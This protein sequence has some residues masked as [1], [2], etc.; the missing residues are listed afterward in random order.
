MLFEATKW[1][2]TAGRKGASIILVLGS[3]FAA[4]A[5]L[6]DGALTTQ[7][8]SDESSPRLDTSL[9]GFST[10]AE[11]GGGGSSMPLVLNATGNGFDFDL[12][13]IDR[14]KVHFYLDSPLFVDPLH[15][16]VESQIFSF[17]GRNALGL[18]A[19]LDVPF[20]PA[21][22]F[23]GE[24]RQQREQMKFQPLGSIQ[25][26]DG[27]LSRDS[28]TASGCRFVD[29][30]YSGLNQGEFRL[31]GRY[32]TQSSSTAISWFT[33]RSELVDTRTNQINNFQTASS[34]GTDLLTPVL[35][36]PLLPGLPVRQPMSY[37]DGQASGVDLS[38]EL[39]VATDNHGDVRF[40]LALTRVLE[41]E[42][43]GL[44]NSLSPWNWAIS[45]AF[46]TAQ[47]NVEWSRGDFSGGIQGFYRDQVDFL[48]RG[49]LDSLTTF[50]V[51]FTWRTPWNADLSV[52]A[53]NILNS[54]A[55]DQGSSDSQPNDPF[56]S[57]YGR[58]PYVR[59]KQDL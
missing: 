57:I 8:A 32:D 37:F 55:D 1:V 24:V 43:S 40:G 53:S 36:N 46:N 50:D 58:I 14:Q 10:S 52:G 27:V 26:T 20:S 59:Y 38:F 31:G 41:A 47:M 49:S 4:S 18:D 15:M 51:H 25:C 39:G 23:T 11:G 17:P 35:S 30:S 5:L 3:W 12:G 13:G 16:G 29:D 33:Q 45:D 56:E 44:D 7:T 48:N 6:A 2:G 34:L 21:L 22:S 9:V 28:Y 54:G 42:Y 19:T